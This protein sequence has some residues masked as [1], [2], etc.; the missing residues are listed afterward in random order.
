MTE[1]EITM[2]HLQLSQ[3]FPN[4]DIFIGT[5]RHLFQGK[6][7]KEWWLKIEGVFDMESFN[8][9]EELDR[10]AN[11]I[12]GTNKYQELCPEIPLTEHLKNER[13]DDYY[14]EPKNRLGGLI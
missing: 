9:W 11:Y 7:I 3:V 6:I 13:F 12:M 14:R 5:D 4:T 1:K 10:C 8:S 2:L